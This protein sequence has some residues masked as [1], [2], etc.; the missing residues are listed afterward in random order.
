M[1]EATFQVSRE[2]IFSPCVIM[3]N[4][5]TCMSKIRNLILVLCEKMNSYILVTKIPEKVKTS[6][7]KKDSLYS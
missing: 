5:V 3:E 4:L 6:Q 1:T 2:R 7:R